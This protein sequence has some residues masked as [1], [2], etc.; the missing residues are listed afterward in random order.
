MLTEVG[1]MALETSAHQEMRDSERELFFTFVRQHR[2]RNSKYQK[3]I[4]PVGFEL[5]ILAVHYLS[6]R[7]P[8][9]IRPLRIRLNLFIYAY[10]NTKRERKITCYNTVNNT[11]K[12]SLML[13][14]SPGKHP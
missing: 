1:E 11:L 5:E 14:S 8:H 2:T 6:M 4:P 13:L 12:K 3:R 7:P 10:Y 9:R